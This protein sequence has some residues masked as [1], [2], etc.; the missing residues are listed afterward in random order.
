M[1]DLSKPFDPFQTHER[2]FD[3][4]CGRDHVKH[5]VSG[6]L[7]VLAQEQDTIF[8]SP[9]EL[10]VRG[11]DGTP[12][13][14]FVVGMRAGKESYREN[15]PLDIQFLARASRTQ[16]DISVCEWYPVYD[17]GAEIDVTLTAI[18]EWANGMEATIEGTILEGTREV[19]FFDTRYAAKKP[20]YRI[21]GTYKFK[22]AALAYFAELLDKPKM[23]LSAEEAEDFA[24]KTGWKVKRDAN[25]KAKPMSINMA[26]FVA[27]VSRG[28][29]QPD[30]CEFQ[31]KIFEMDGSCSCAFQGEFLIMKI[32]CARSDDGKDVLIPLVVDKKH[33]SRPWPRVGKCIRGMLWMQGFC[34]NAVDKHV[35]ESKIAELKVCGGPYVLMSKIVSD[36]NAGVA[37]GAIKAA[38]DFLF[39]HGGMT[40]KGRSSAEGAVPPEFDQLVESDDDRLSCMEWNVEHSDATLIVSRYDERHPDRAAA[41]VGDAKLAYELAAKH[42]K[43]CVAVFNAEASNEVQ[44]IV[45]WLVRVKD[46]GGLA[47]GVVVNIAGASE[48]EMPGIQE[49][50]MILI[51]NLIVALKIEAKGN[52]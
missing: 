49:T 33:F 47:D 16:D 14:A 19:V 2:H 40:P 41:L 3:C 39:P 42:G 46:R 24:Q 34:V 10:P 17:N 50:T 31:S 45:D 36:G 13:N 8:V 51:R 1:E 26:D 35:S 6:R 48:T 21:G 18:H 30:N 43:P 44:S 20:D 28:G 9:K 7:E 29:A 22:L 32:A 25:G 12:V 4:V 27:C 15:F 37:R 52:L 11:S 23:H 38:K 5:M